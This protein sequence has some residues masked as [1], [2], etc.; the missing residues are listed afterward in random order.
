M[1]SNGFSMNKTLN[2]GGRIIDLSKPTVMGILNITPDSFFDGSRYND[3]SQA[4]KKA[5][6]MLKDGAT[7]IDV[8]GYSS[9]PGAT[10]ISIEE[11][12]ERV[13][14]VIAAIKKNLPE[15]VISIDTFRSKVAIAAVEEGASM[16]ND[17]SGGELDPKM[18]DTVSNLKVPYVLMHMQGNPQT[19]TQ[20]TQYNNLVNEMLD[21]FHQRIQR[22]QDLGVKDI[23]VDPG[24]GF[25]KT[26]SQ[27]FELLNHLDLFK[28]T[29]K[30][31]L[32]GL[33]RK[34]MIWKTLQTN[35][36]GALNGT[37][38]LNTVA[39]LKGASILRVHEVKQAIEIIKLL[40]G[41]KIG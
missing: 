19:M 22:L 23:V 28:I 27:N 32:A 4:L 21:Y 1:Q 30:P 15:A 29:G 10:D 34:S 36:E 6:Q 17:I 5:E 14:P 37:T 7:F 18:F 26:V 8:G 33:S 2:A 41:I 39:L 31:I 24:F 12:I 11:E 25:A 3:P 9:R 40:E 20:L 16:I 35:P 38:A 13:V